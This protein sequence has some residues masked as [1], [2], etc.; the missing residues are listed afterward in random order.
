[1]IWLPS[2]ERRTTSEI[3]R[4]GR[5]A[6]ERYSTDFVDYDALHRWSVSRPDE[7]WAAVW[8]FFQA[9]PTRPPASPALRG[10]AMPGARWFAGATLNYAENALRHPADRLAL[11]CTDES[12]Q[13]AAVTYG[14]LT[15]HVANARAG[16]ERAGVGPGSRVVAVL[17]NRLEA[18]V[19]LLATASLGAIWS[20]CPPEY[21]RDS[22]L[23][24]FGQLEPVV[25]IGATEHQYAGRQHDTSA[26]TAALAEN[27]PSLRRVVV[28]GDASKVP[29]SV[30][31]S[32]FGS[33]APLAFARTE[34]NDPLWTLYS[35]GTTG[36]PKAIVHSHGGIVL[37]ELK[38]I[39]LHFDVKPGDR[40]F[41]YTTTGW[42]LWNY[43][44][45]SLLVGATAILYDGAPDPQMIWALLRRNRAVVAGAS[46]G[47]LERTRDRWDLIPPPPLSL[48][49]LGVTGSPLSTELHRWLAEALG[50]DVL[51][52]PV[53][54]GT[55]IC[56][57][58]VGP[59][60]TLASRP[61]EMQRSML[62]VAS[63][64]FDDDG[65]EVIDEVGELV[66]TAPLP[67][68]PLELW[69]DDDGQRYR[70]SYFDTWDGV[71][72]QGDWAMFHPD[73]SVVV[74]GRS[75]ATL[76][77]GGVRMGTSEFYRALAQ[78]TEIEDSLVVDTSL[79]A[80]EGELVLFVVVRD[81]SLDAGLVQRIRDELRLRLSPRHVPDRVLEV[82]E[83]PYT[84]TGKKCEVPVK[85]ILL[86]MGNPS[87]DSGVV[88][89]PAAFLPVVRLAD[90]LATRP[91]RAEAALEDV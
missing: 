46:P 73:G 44:V 7:F 60:P 87:V 4:F 31:W 90:A 61:G 91:G 17:P 43:V 8:D 6:G 28:V 56:S 33:P 24:R 55:D 32:R 51:V 71:W 65:Q 62:G 49:T 67:S 2:D 63:A 40:F 21:G 34:F 69:G 68:M 36:K 47:F 9:T 64:A 39:G 78:I 89:N 70:A 38:A 82:D 35:S 13:D 57:G 66:V 19:A 80:A 16:L 76:N 12:Q 83:I 50:A 81:G 52:A 23:D 10:S 18:V 14:E 5:W 48:R 84:L 79:N 20:I 37:E 22:I 53:C 42:M 75:D 74:S 45:S 58:F 54:G 85:R 25:L 86:G 27:L 72:R 77:R 29:G 15:E 30:A 59:V 88:R 26:T 41:W 1:M 3:G 11:I